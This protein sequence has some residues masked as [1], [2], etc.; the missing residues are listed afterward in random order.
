MRAK[1]IALALLLLLGGCENY[2]E[3]KQKAQ[4][5]VNGGEWIVKYTSYDEVPQKVNSDGIELGLSM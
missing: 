1:L 3:E 2:S 5:L 4:M